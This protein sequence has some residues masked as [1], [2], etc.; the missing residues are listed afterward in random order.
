MSVAHCCADR[1]IMDLVNLEAVMALLP[2]VGGSES[3]RLR[4][5]DG[6]HRSSEL[7][8]EIMFLW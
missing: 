6:C 3:I 5:C 8:M 4:P 2:Y 1:V 7:R